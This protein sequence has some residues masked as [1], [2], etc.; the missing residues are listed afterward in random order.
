MTAPLRIVMVSTSLMRGG[1]ETQ[2]FLLARE[3]ARRGHAL[4]V[5]TMRDPEAYAADLADLRIP[6]V[7]LGMRRG[8]PDPRALARLAGVVR[9]AR[10]HVV[11]AHMVHANLLARLARPLAW[12]PVLIS[13][14]HSPIEGGRWREI[15]Y[16]LTDRLG[17]LTTHVARAAVERYVEVGAVPRERIRFVPNG[18]DLAAHG[19]DPE[20]RRRL[21]ADLGLGDDAFVWLSVGR[22]E[23][24]KEFPVL[25][26]AVAA[27]RPRAGALRLLVAGSGP[28]RAA[29]EAQARELGSGEAVRFL[30]PRDDV[31][32]LLSAADA[33]VLASAWEGLPMVLLEAG[34]AGLP[35]VASDV[36]GVREATGPAGVLVPSGD[37][38]AL[39]EAL[40]RVGEASDAQRRAL[41]GAIHD[42]VAASFGLAGVVDAWESLYR[43]LVAARGRRGGGA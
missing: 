34:A 42:H 11:H 38:A 14:A 31:P 36:G 4:T 30:G 24:P 6:L 25:L 32:A 33:F 2:V 15:A 37:V 27:A 21:R 29:L 1:A 3:L 8:V 41:G 23:P 26:R 43:E 16:R 19:H 39:T 5:V 18:L 17:T 9:G 7:T 13:T 20:A 28:D 22:L 35:V 10:P 12:A 40:V